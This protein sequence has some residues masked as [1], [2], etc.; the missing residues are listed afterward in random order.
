VDDWR[1]VGF[2]A[3]DARLRVSLAQR[4]QQA[5]GYTTVVEFDD[6]EVVGQEWYHTRLTFD[7]SPAPAPQ[8]LR[9]QLDATL[10]DVVDLNGAFPDVRLG[11]P[12]RAVLKYDPAQLPSEI[13]DDKSLYDYR[14]PGWFGVA[15][16]TIE[17][18]RTGSE[19]HLDNDV[20]DPIGP[21]VAVFNGLLESTGVGALQQIARP[22]GMDPGSLLLELAGP[23]TAE[24]DPRLPVELNLAD[25][26]LAHLEYSA[27]DVDE[28]EIVLSE[29]LYAEI[30]KLTPITTPVLP[31]DYDYDG[32]VDVADYGGWKASFG[33]N[34][35]DLYADGNANGI[36]DAADYVVWRNALS[37]AASS[38]AGSRVSVPEPA[39]AL[40]CIVAC[41]TQTRR[42][43]RRSLA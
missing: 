30:H 11:D 29:Y 25:W 7:S 18:P 22:S 23:R 43:E 4:P 2:E 39:T 12:V 24:F 26:P 15:S 28:A 40:L 35:S 14:H 5:N 13:Y 27:F 8:V 37:R 10:T 41:I 42:R 1:L 31:G 16:V 32:D 17:N 21:A 36:V 34:R 33:F 19:I 3:I 6:Y 38:T 9:W 20:S